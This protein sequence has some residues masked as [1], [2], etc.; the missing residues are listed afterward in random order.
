MNN[1][2]ETRAGFPHIHYVLDIISL[3]GLDVRRRLP[4]T[5]FFGTLYW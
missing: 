2:V 3:V 4:C 1:M 5:V